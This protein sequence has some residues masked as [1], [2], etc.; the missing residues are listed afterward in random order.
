VSRHTTHPAER[1]PFLAIG[2]TV[3]ARGNND[4]YVGRVIDVLPGRVVELDDASWVANSGRMSEFVRL[5]RADG[6]E[7]EPVGRVLVAWQEIID[8]PHTLFKEAV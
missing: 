4:H 5:G 6:M 3:F 1:E 8:W 7:I 2:R